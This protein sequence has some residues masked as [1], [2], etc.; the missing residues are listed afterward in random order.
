MMQ[1]LS[2]I[3]QRT[4][5][6]LQAYA[7]SQIGLSNEQTLQ[8]PSVV[9]VEGSHRIQVNPPSY[10]D[11]SSGEDSDGEEEDERLVG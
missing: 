1:Y 2:I 8:L 5:E 4:S 3:E 10:D 6:I 11:M 9:P 7:A